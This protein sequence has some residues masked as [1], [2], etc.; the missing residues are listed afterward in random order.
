MLGFLL[1]HFFSCGAASPPT[2]YFFTAPDA[3]PNNQLPHV[4]MLGNGIIGLAL[5]ATVR[6]GGAQTIGAGRKNTL[7][8]WIGS[9]NMWSCQYQCNS[10][11]PGCCRVVSLGGVSLSLLPTFAASTPLSF[12]AEQRTIDGTLYVNQSSP[13][14]STLE[15]VIQLHPD[16]TVASISMVY[17]ARGSDPQT[18]A[19]NASVWVS[20]PYRAPH[21]YSVGCMDASGVNV[22]CG[23]ATGVF[24]SRK[25]CD[26]KSSPVPMWAGLALWA[27]PSSKV[28]GSAITSNA[29]GAVWEAVLNVEV[30]SGQPASV[31]TLGEAETRVYNASDP[32]IAA[33][34]L[35]AST[36][37]GEVAA[38]AA[39]FWGSFWGVSGLETPTLP[40]I[41][42]LWYGAQF[43]LAGTSPRAFNVTA[44]PGLYGVWATSDAAEWSGDYTLDYNQESTYFGTFSSNHPE[45]SEGYYAFV[46]DWMPWGLQHAAAE[47]K[48]AGISA[49][50]ANNT[51]HYGCHLAPWGMQS[52]DTSTYM[53]WNGQFASLLFMNHWEYLRNESFARS[54][55][56][57]LLDGLNAWFA[58]YFDKNVTGPGPED[59]VWIDYRA[60][61][62]DEA[63]EGQKV[64][65]P[66]MAISMAARTLSMQ[67]DIADALN[68]TLPSYLPDLLDHLSPFNTAPWNYTSAGP[69]SSQNFTLYNDTRCFN[70]VGQAPVA[71]SPASCQTACADTPG[72]SNFTWSYDLEICW[73]Y[74][75]AVKVPSCNSGVPAY[76]SGANM[77]PPPNT[78][79]LTVWSSYHTATAAQ[80]FFIG[81]WYSTW[82]SVRFFF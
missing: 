77:G 17:T 63:L 58:C 24:A 16:N 31:L 49:Q 51:L 38:S 30:T 43:A 5:D 64:V 67:K 39:S 10:Y 62:P 79:Q 1:L 36:P 52:D 71:S 13:A 21:P 14:G 82:P 54:S 41:H 68:I 22:S 29:S 26:P 4:P 76:I 2:G 20:A 19:L 25:A 65:N 72:C 44:A 18:L 27:T 32:A 73:L 47:A 6:R 61:D 81:V 78:T 53:H 80:S 55:I 12:A 8:I 60:A 33:S 66:Q 69:P 3:L 35:A 57:P 7:D 45:L 42:D 9:N 37:P 59:Y 15:T 34:V 70:D 74:D 11:S 23:A 40:Y 46:L 48:R 75:A 56:Y 50:C 28:V